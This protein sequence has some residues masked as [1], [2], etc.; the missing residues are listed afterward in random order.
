MFCFLILKF[1]PII[2]VVMGTATP[3]KNI[4]KDGSKFIKGYLGLNSIPPTIVS[5]LIA[6]WE[7]FH[8]HSKGMYFSLFSKMFQMVHNRHWLKF[9]TLSKS[10]PS[11]SLAG[12]QALPKAMSNL[13]DL[14]IWKGTFCRLQVCHFNMVMGKSPIEAS[15][16]II[17]I[18]TYKDKISILLKKTLYT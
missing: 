17:M 13:G 2:Y 14:E 15:V 1:K 3:N 8:S 9:L 18:K 7:Y 5:Q 11:S 12:S 4:Q 16:I 10:R 6:K